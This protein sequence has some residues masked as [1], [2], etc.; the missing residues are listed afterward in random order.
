MKARKK[1]WMWLASALAVMI[2]GALGVGAALAESA[3]DPTALAAALTDHLAAGRFA[4]V[5]AYFDE[6]MKAALPAG[7]L[8]AVWRSLVLQLGSFRTAGQPYVA[9]PGP[10]AQVRQ[11]ATFVLGEVDLLFVFDDRG[12][13]SG[14]WVAPPAPPEEREGPA[15][16][17]A[18]GPPPYADP[19]RFTE[20]ELTFGQPSL[21]LAGTLSLPRGAGPFPGVVLV[22]G[23][24]PSDRDETVGPNKPFRDL[25][26]GLASQGIAVFR[27]DKR[28]LVHGARLAPGDVSLEAEVIE[29]A[30]GAVQLL[31][32]RPEVSRVYVV[33]HSLGATMA[34]TLA[35]RSEQ[36]AG[37][38]LLAPMARRISQVLPEQVAYI[39]RADGTVTPEEKAQ[40]E[41]VQEALRAALSGE[42]D[43]AEMVLG[44]PAA[45]WQELEAVD[46]VRVAQGL[47]IPL[48]VLQGGRD[49][50]VTRAD[51]DLFREGLA[52]HAEAEFHLFPE[53]N[54]L[55][56]AGSG[57]STPAE[58]QVPAH[59]DPKVVETVARWI[60]EQA[61]R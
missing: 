27:Y 5:E 40:V 39:A 15:D 1:S 10:P 44:A 53:L 43:P 61:S 35:T 37:I 18:G 4:E 33:G 20:V 54:H 6:G 59:V 2:A 34:P 46:P 38:A 19:D 3:V 8:E 47:Q 48:L 9:E 50:Q 49:Y 51:F 14:F 29:D 26:W 13:L 56:M 22:H 25:A 23:S 55:F 42:L 17:A 58:Y 36:V 45:Y 28:T 21:E 60:L 16:E 41:A 7:E 31:A 12:R 52:G 30:L 24:G 32:S 11:P 57:S